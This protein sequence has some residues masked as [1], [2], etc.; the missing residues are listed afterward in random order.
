MTWHEFKQQVDDVL[1]E[2]GVSEDTELFLI[3]VGPL[4]INSF[5]I[6]T[7]KEHDEISIY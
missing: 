7:N 6:E 3:D 5:T 2:K 1:T 4:N